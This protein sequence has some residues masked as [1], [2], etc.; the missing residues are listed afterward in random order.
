MVWFG[1][2]WFGLVWI[3]FVWFGLVWFGF[4][5][6]GLVWFGFVS[7]GLRL[8][9]CLVVCVV[10]CRVIFSFS[11]FF[12]FDSMHRSCRANKYKLRV[13]LKEKKEKSF[14]ILLS[15][16]DYYTCSSCNIPHR[17]QW[18]PQCVGSVMVNCPW[19]SSP[20]FCFFFPAGPSLPW[21]HVSL[22]RRALGKKR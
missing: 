21:V 17:L 1:L 13:P 14:S 10:S 9:S 19:T 11:F 7:F 5:W 6:F 16:V 18:C 4:V 22:P 12:W 15:V 3:G 2:V 20:R 8:V